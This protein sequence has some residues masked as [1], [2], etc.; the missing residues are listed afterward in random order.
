MRVLAV[1]LLPDGPISPLRSPVVA[2]GARRVGLVEEADVLVG[3]HRREDAP[4]ALRRLCV[5]V[6]PPEDGLGPARV[7]HAAMVPEH[8]AQLRVDPSLDRVVRAG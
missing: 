1:E 4:G 6:A 5:Q 7:R 3:R 2:L 8:V